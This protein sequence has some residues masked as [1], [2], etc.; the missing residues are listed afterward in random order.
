MGVPAYWHQVFIGLTLVIS[1][2]VTAIRE[3][4]AKKNAGGINV[5]S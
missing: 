1:I 3:K 4:M 5:E 2:S